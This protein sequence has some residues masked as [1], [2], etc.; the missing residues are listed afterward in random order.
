MYND[1][2]MN[3]SNT[4]YD[5]TLAVN[6]ESGYFV[7]YGILI[8][9][10]LMS[11]MAARTRTGTPEALLGSSL[12]VTFLNVMLWLI[13]L[14]PTYTIIVPMLLTI[15]GIVMVLMSEKSGA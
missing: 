13:N 14:I 3:T 10:W 2:F 11:F 15:I 6:T 8:I 1:T 4:I 9:V 5:V 12:I 7:A